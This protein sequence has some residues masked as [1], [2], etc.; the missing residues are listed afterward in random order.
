MISDIKPDDQ[1]TAVS[2]FA[3]PQVAFNIPVAKPFSMLNEY[4]VVATYRVQLDELSLLKDKTPITGTTEITTDGTAASLSLRD[5]LPPQSTLVATAKVHVERQDGS[6]WVAL[7]D[8][9]DKVDYE[10]K[11]T[12]FTTG[13]APDYIPWENVTYAYPIKRQY[14]LLVKEYPKGYI[15]LKRGQPYLF[16]KWKVS[17]DLKPVKGPAIGTD[18]AYDKNMT[19]VNFN[20][21]ASLLKETI[22]TF[23]LRG[24]SPDVSAAA[25]NVS[26]TTTTN[27]ADGDTTT[28]TTNTLKG[29]A[30]AAV[31]KELI[32]YSFRTSKYGTF[33]EKMSD[34]TDPK[35]LY[36][37]ATNYI[38][39]IGQRLTMAETFDKFEIAGDAT[40][41]TKPLINLQAG[42]NNIWLRDTLMPLLY[43]GYPF[44]PSM[45]ITRDLTSAAG[46]PPLDAVRLYN[47]DYS[48]YQLEDVA[49]ADG[50]APAISGPICYMYYVSWVAYTDYYEL[51]AKASKLYLNRGN[52]TPAISRLITKNIFP[53]LQGYLYYPVEMEYRLP[54]S[55]NITSSITKSIYY[56]L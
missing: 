45:T 30:I 48:L 3:T 1:T 17:A 47:N 49:V 29:N 8:S 11:S 9:L 39:V 42:M 12:I 31:S 10:T 55:N 2:V 5:I 53:D 19:Q 43:T 34:V 25:D 13:E 16:E 38:S 51:Q 32:G 21:P 40:F 7:K 44:D 27:A 37:V 50:A 18:V 22:Y 41:S 35:N 23:S 52:I 56:K 36:D 15:K 24:I 33:T 20:I 14:N 46:I 54:G 28:I 26:T 4:D 6:A